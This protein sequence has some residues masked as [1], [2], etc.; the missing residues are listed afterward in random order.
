MRWPRTGAPNPRDDLTTALVVTEV[1]GERLNSAEIASFFILL[2]I[3]GNETTRNAISHGV[4]A[5][6]RY[7]EQ[8]DIWW[9]DQPTV[10]PRWR[11][12]SRWASPG[13]LHAAHRQA[14]RR[15]QR[16]ADHAGRQ[17]HHV[18][19]RPITDE[20]SSIIRG[21]ST[22]PGRTTTTSDSAAAGAFLPG[23]QSRPSRDRGDLRGDA[24]PDPGHRGHRGAGDAAVVIHSRHQETPG[25]LDPRKLNPRKLDRVIETAGGWPARVWSGRSRSGRHARAIHRPG[26]WPTP[27]YAPTRSPFYEELRGRGPLVRGRLSYL[28]VD[29]AVAHELLRADDFRVIVLV[30]ACRLHGVDQGNISPFDGGSIKAPA[31]TCSPPWNPR[32]KC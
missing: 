20:A 27:R 31:V 13:G 14:G 1:D 10:R 24:Q 4:L 2:A 19:L 3:A 32:N 11:R 21:S 29:H 23:R 8:R 5:L 30:P 17:G 26:W 6:T 22:W 18:V 12:S 25:E 7:P 28:T 16:G 9:N 15:R